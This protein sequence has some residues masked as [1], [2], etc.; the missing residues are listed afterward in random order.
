MALIMN[1]MSV[2]RILLRGLVKQ[3]RSSVLSKRAE[4][5]YA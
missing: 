3:W 2:P 1:A 5:M 4:G